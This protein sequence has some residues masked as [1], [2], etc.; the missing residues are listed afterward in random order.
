MMTAEFIRSLA[1]SA[2]V[3]CALCCIVMMLIDSAQI[4]ITPQDKRMRLFMAFTYLVAALCWTGLVLYITNR[5]LFANYQPLFLLTL[6][7][8]QVLIYRFV[9]VITATGERWKFCRLHFYIPLLIAA[10]S[11]FCA[12]SIPVEQRIRI[13][14]EGNTVPVSWCYVM[15]HMAT[16]VLFI[17]YNTL[18]PVLGLIRMRNYRRRIVNYS[19]DIQRTSVKWL[20]IMQVLT[21]ITVPVPL[22]GLL[23]GINTFTSLW[24][25]W[26]GAFPAVAVY[27]I[28]CHNLLSGNY[29]IVPPDP[30]EKDDPPGRASISRKKFEQYMREK[31]PYLNP[32]LRITE[33]AGGLYTNRS[34]VS[35][36]INKEYGMN[37]SRYIN[38]KRLEELE[39]LRSSP[40]CAQYSNTDILLMAGFGSYRSYLR[41][42]SEDDKSRVMKLFE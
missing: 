26:L 31:K 10:V 2:P 3:I 30:K 11:V 8:D 25:T 14:F 19:A 32:K 17:V 37:F 13:I 39:K 20:F 38:R 34:Y 41:V 15:L 33:V 23:Q 22:A 24:F 9:Y 36:F 1:F 5:K 18:Y 12:L 16:C 4:G 40:E 29:L 6:M 35:T 28:I 27:L 21:L 7:F 42:K